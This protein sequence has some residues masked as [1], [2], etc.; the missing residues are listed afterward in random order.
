MVRTQ[1]TQVD[2]QVVFHIRYV[3]RV[4]GRKH[5]LTRCV[6]KFNIV[7]NI[8]PQIPLKVNHNTIIASEA[9]LLHELAG[10]FLWYIYIYI[11]LCPWAVH[12][13]PV[14]AQRANVGPAG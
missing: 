12:L 2:N 3:L 6:G 4:C 9:S 7:T 13:A 1:L 10:A 5:K 14:N 8:L 11:Y